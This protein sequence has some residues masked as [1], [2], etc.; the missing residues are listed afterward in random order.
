[1]VDGPPQAFY[2]LSLSWGCFRIAAVFTPFTFRLYNLMMFEQLWPMKGRTAT[3]VCG[4]CYLG[5]LGPR[6]CM[7]QPQVH[8]L[9]GTTLPLD[10]STKCVDP[11]GNSKWQGRLSKEALQKCGSS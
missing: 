5:T 9:L 1:M 6:S 2:L 11:V 7:A 8:E 10:M 4:V 3:T